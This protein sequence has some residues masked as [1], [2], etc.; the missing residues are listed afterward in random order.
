[1]NESKNSENPETSRFQ[2]FQTQMKLP[3]AEANHPNV[4]VVDVDEPVGE[5]DPPLGEAVPAGVDKAAAV[6][7]HE[8]GLADQVDL[9]AELDGGDAR[10]I[11][12]EGEEGEEAR[13]LAIDLGTQIEQG[14]AGDD[15]ALGDRSMERGGGCPDLEVVVVFLDEVSV[16][17][18]LLEQGDGVDR[19]QVDGEVHEVRGLRGGHLWPPFGL[20]LAFGS[21]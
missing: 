10:L 20:G 16:E 17:V 13:P 4:G 14:L 15:V 12:D 19:G 18:V 11:L 9:A 8:D 6:L 5:D 3:L 21:E 2:F 1:M 7:V